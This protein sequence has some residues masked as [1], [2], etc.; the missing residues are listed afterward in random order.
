M[1]DVVNAVFAA[2]KAG[3]AEDL[4]ELFAKSKAQANIKDSQGSSPLHY[5]AAG[6]TGTNY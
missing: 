3:N 4:K 6:T 2:A 5:A 1:T